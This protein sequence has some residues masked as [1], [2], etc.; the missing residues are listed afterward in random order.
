[1]TLTPLEEWKA[2]YAG[3]QAKLDKL[4]T[5]IQ[6]IEAVLNDFQSNMATS[7][8]YADYFKF[9]HQRSQLYELM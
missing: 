9:T 5:N 4:N 8:M 1:M 6:R 7:D 3:L 2:E